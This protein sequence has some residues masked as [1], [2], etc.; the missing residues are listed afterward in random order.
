M[1][2][3]TQESLVA[4]ARVASQPSPGYRSKKRLFNSFELRLFRYTLVLLSLVVLTAL[5]LIILW[6]FGL[7][8]K[9]FYSLLLSLSIAGILALVLYP[10]VDFLQ[11]RIHMPRLLSIVLL[12]VALSISIGGLIF[13]LVPILVRQIVQLMTVL[14]ETLASWQAYFAIQFPGFSAMIADNMENSNGEE[15]QSILPG[16]E[17]SGRTLLSYLSLLV[18]ISFVPLFLFFAL[19]SGN[20]LRGKVSE[21]LSI[22]H[23]PTQQKALYF[24]DVFVGYVTAF[25]QGQLMIAICMGALYALGFSLVGLEF[26][27]LA[28][29]ILGMLNIVPFLGSL[30]GLLVVL[31]MAYFQVD[32]GMELLVFTAL[33]FA[34]VQMV[35]SGLLTP[36]IMANRSGL[37]PAVVIISLFFWGTAFNG[38][39]GL[40]LAVP[41]TAFFVA[42]WGEIKYSL[43]TMLS[44]RDTTR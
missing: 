42:I 23:Q 41:L 22:F 24:I 7:F 1:S 31:P 32:G 35:E 18:G 9:I 19:L 25:F 8:L 13:L 33:V 21:L 28:G 44:N 39:I 3:N 36:N 17:D 10:V 16:L 5:I 27:V 12:L 43:E 29:L 20:A 34:V 2:Q 26:G 11:N 38:I 30:I 40:V 4:G 37:H 6:S 15:S 14:P